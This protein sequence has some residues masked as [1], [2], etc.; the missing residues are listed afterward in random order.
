MA[1]TPVPD[2][3][4]AADSWKTLLEEKKPAVVE[5]RTQKV[6]TSADGVQRQAWVHIHS[7][8]EFDSDGNVIKI[9]G[10]IYDITKYKEAEELQQVR[11]EEALE[12][13]RQKE[14]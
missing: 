2:I 12:A 9:L 13:K 7:F 6:Y 10:T 4:I 3:H 1:L 14:K 5:G 11:I 8:P